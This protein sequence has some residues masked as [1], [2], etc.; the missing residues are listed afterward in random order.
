M[1]I[2]NHFIYS[3]TILCILY[4]KAIK[5]VMLLGNNTFSINIIYMYITY[6]II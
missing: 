6:M 5:Y 2:K 1:Y 4:K 3:K